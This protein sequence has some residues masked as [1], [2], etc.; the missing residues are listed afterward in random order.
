MK[1]TLGFAQLGFGLAGLLALFR[2]QWAALILCWA[3]ACVIGMIGTRVVRKVEGISEGGRGS[4]RNISAA[5]E[6]LRQGQYE[7]ANGFA[8]NA[9]T[10]FRLGGDRELLVPALII[11]TVTLASVGKFAD[12]RTSL[13]RAKEAIAQLPVEVAR[14]GRDFVE[15]LSLI[16]DELSRMQPDSYYVV[17]LFLGFND[18][19]A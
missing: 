19:R 4:I 6:K 9:V 7:S 3:G 2:G 8:M 17:S 18:Q 5:V 10:S 11:Q 1:A 13:A 12:A 15:L 14:E 16:D